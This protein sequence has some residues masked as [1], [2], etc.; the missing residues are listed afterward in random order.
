M[1]QA[2]PIK[3]LYL[4]VADQ[5]SAM[6]RSGEL[7]IGQRLPSER[8]LAAR[9]SVSRPTVREAIVTLEVMKLVEV[10]PGSGVY[11]REAVG[12]RIEIPED[13][14]GPFEI[15][16]ARKVLESEIAAIA[17]DRISND[18]LLRLKTLLKKL[19]SPT[20]SVT[21]I[22]RHDQEFH[23]VIAEATGNSA[24][25]S[26]V[27]WLWDLRR[28]SEI[29]AMFHE[30]ARE[31]GSRPA[32]DEHRAILAALMKRDARAAHD[33]MQRHLVRVIED[34]TERSLG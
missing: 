12:S 11:V 7:K 13:L 8:D 6:I 24:L 32:V 30:H 33:A 23:T 25:V 3:R 4:H 15:L 34:L 29:S 1:P 22:E 10:R 16:E 18:D 5:L 28:E 2:V 17:A 21:E 31:T 14:P 27:K 19:D 26:C 9:F 20:R